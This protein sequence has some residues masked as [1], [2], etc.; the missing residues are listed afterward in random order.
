MGSDQSFRLSFYRYFSGVV[1]KM[2][3]VEVSEVDS[4][5][6]AQLGQVER[7]PQ[8]PAFQSCKL[9]YSSRKIS[10]CYFVAVLNFPFLQ[11]FVTV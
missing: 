5:F 2:H 3:H 11:V 7:A 8:G 1:T 6:G 10:Q 9:L 4:S